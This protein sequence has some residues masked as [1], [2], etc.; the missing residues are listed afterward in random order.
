MQKPKSWPYIALA[1]LF[2]II[3]V[4]VKPGEKPM[5]P[6]S[7][8]KSPS[9]GL[10]TD[11]SASIST[12]EDS[13][14]LP[15][16]PEPPP[17]S[18]SEGLQIEW[19][20]DDDSYAVLGLGSCTDSYIVIPERYEGFPVTKI[21]MSAFAGES[22]TGIWIPDTV[23]VIEG[24]AFAGC[25]E[26]SSVRIGDGVESIGG[27]AFAT[28]VNLCEVTMGKNVRSIY[29]QAF[30]ECKSLTTIRLP[31]GLQSI[32]Y[33]A[34]YGT[35]LYEIEIPAS[36]TSLGEQ[37]LNRSAD[38]TKITVAAGNPVYHSSGS[39][40][41][42]TAS[43]KVIA[44]CRTS[45]I[46]NDGTVTEIGDYVFWGCEGLSEIT[47]PRGIKRIGE[48]AFRGC[49]LLDMIRFEGTQSEWYAITKGY[50]WSYESHINTIRCTDGDLEI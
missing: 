11:I 37:L 26:L 12:P 21:Q 39:C 36:V 15:V 13:V 32:D 24:D 9:G 14:P 29:N 1:L 10:Q 48:Y 41:I 22:I 4:T 18:P 17:E 6:E 8:T 46:P 19:R 40:I 42:E 5:R 2:L 16:L 7:D 35:G 34:F 38:L 25:L 47:I 23:T 30:L 49:F 44:G 45:V 43:R 20:R 28:C 27:G 31:E 33:A 3:M 50:N